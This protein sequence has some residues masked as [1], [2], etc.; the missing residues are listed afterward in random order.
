MWRCL[1]DSVFSGFDTIPDCDRQTDGR[2]HNYSIYRASIA[3]RGKNG[4]DVLLSLCLNERGD[5]VVFVGRLFHNLLLL[6]QKCYGTM[7]S[8]GHRTCDS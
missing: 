4:I 8:V 6:M 1:R 2:T 3:S 7:L 5:L